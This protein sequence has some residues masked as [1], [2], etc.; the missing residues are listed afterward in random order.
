MECCSVC[1]SQIP[2]ANKSLHELMCRRH[3]FQCPVCSLLVSL[4]EKDAHL[5]LHTEKQCRWCTFTAP[6]IE[7]HEL[8]CEFQPR[9]CDFCELSY[10]QDQFIEH[11]TVCGSRTERCTTCGVY[12]RLRDLQ[13]HPQICQPPRPHRQRHKLQRP[14]PTAATTT[15]TAGATPTRDTDSTT[16]STGADDV[17]VIPCELCEECV[18]ISRYP[19]H[20]RECPVLVM[21]PEFHDLATIHSNPHPPIPSN[22]VQEEVTTAT[23]TRTT[24]TWQSTTQHTTSYQRSTGSAGSN[25]HCD[26]EH[27][28]KDDDTTATLPCEFCG[29][30]VDITEFD[31]HQRQCQQQSLQRFQLALMT[32]LGLTAPSGAGATNVVVRPLDPAALLASLLQGTTAAGNPAATTTATTAA[33]VYRQPSCDDLQQPGQPNSGY[34][35]QPAATVYHSARFQPAYHTQYEPTV[36]PYADSPFLGIPVDADVPLG[37]PVLSSSER[38]SS[39][40]G[41]PP[42]SEVLQV[43]QQQQLQQTTT[44]VSDVQQVTKKRSVLWRACHK[45]KKMLTRK[46]AQPAG[47]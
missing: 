8:V 5:Q 42:R 37:V 19:A 17:V 26:D 45:L 30:G 23:T 24:T 47:V 15:T 14:V 46:K 39:P 27:T 33:A 4:S 32:G 2:A 35:H 34:Q 29:Q 44:G 18:P 40:G 28:T 7:T 1:G 16:S 13:T 38:Q 12:V 22:A 9:V 41:A 6:Q 36:Q 43:Q 11:E 20:L 10:P 25:D 21:L 31:E 3:K